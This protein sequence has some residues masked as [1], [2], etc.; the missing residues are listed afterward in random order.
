VTVTRPFVGVILMSLGRHSLANGE[1]LGFALC[2]A[3]STRPSKFRGA[4]NLDSK[5]GRSYIAANC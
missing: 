5:M 3:N 2:W 1:I 4:R